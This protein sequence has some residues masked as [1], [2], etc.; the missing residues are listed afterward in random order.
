MAQQVLQSRF[1]E[2]CDLPAQPNVGLL[3]EVLGEAGD[4][5][6]AFAQWQ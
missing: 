4:I 2:T 3:N 1:I 5:L 6:P